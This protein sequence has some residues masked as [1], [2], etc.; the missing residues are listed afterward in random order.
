MRFCGILAQFGDLQ[1]ASGCV[2]AIFCV[3][4]YA[5]S[6]DAACEIALVTETNAFLW[7]SGAISRFAVGE[8]IVE[9]IY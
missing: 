2:D 6:C 4:F 1:C 9:R 5:L 8:Y 7:E 3:F